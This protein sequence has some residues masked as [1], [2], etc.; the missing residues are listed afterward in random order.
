MAALHSD[1]IPGAATSTAA[2]TP[3]TAPGINLLLSHAQQVQ[4]QA[5]FAASASGPGGLQQAFETAS[6]PMASSS[7]L[8]L[9]HTCQKSVSGSLDDVMGLE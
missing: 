6:S 1:N 4:Q 8:A 2:D 9:L 7:Q 3:S 5:V